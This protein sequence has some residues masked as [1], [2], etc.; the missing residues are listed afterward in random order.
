MPLLTATF[1]FFVLALIAESAVEFA[2]FAVSATVVTSDATLF[3]D[4][5]SLTSS[6][7]LFLASAVKLSFT[8]QIYKHPHNSGCFLYTKIKRKKEKI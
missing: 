6:A 4:D 1:T 7:F 8:Y 2:V 5:A 3:I